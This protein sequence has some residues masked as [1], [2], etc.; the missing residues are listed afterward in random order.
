[1][2][3]STLVPLIGHT[4]ASAALQDCMLGLGMKKMPKGDSTTR[5]RTQDKL[6]SLEFD[7]TESY[8]GRNVREPV[9]D[10][11]FTLE[12][13]DVH[14]GYLGE[15]PFGLSL[16]M[17]RQQVD[18]ALGRALDEDPKAEVQ[19]Y[20]RDDFLIIVFYGGKGRKIDTFRFTRP[21]VHSARKF[22]IELQAA[23]AETP[24]AA[25]QPLSAPELLSFL[26]ASPDDAA[27]GAWLDQHG[28][29]DRPHAAPGVDGHGAA[30]D[31]TLREARLSEIDENERHGVALIY[32]SRESH[33][34]LFSAEAAGQG[35][36]L[37]QAAFYGPGVSGRAGFQGELP[38]GLRFA[39]GPAQVREKLSAPIAR[40]V[41][42]GLPAELW[43]DKDWHLNI[44]YTADAG[45]VAIVH[46]R[47]PNRYDLEM[48]GA[49][50]SEASRNAPDLEKLNAAI[51]LAV[52]DAK[53]QAALAPLAWNQDARDEAGRGDE[54]FRYLKSHG[55]SLYFRDG[56]DVGTTVLAGYCVNRAGDM[57]S[58]GYPGPLPF[59]LA[60]STRLEDIIPRVG[61]DPDA[62]GVA[63][64]T[65]YFLWNL[66]GFR[67]HVLYSLIDWQV[68]R[69]TCSGPVA[70]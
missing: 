27:F 31:E 13:F 46:V 20:R 35:F 59:G 44:S 61:R 6:V 9:G 58:A 51:G 42:H 2:T 65:G 54:V 55:L 16:A 12:S 23:A 48:I 66:P 67:L 32:E 39:D 43:V 40:R 8:M 30:S 50:S 11:G 19:T 57:D 17:D 15:L 5:V 14:Q 52:D 24:G 10:G 21:N 37:K 33:G 64:D 34:R 22:N 41:L 47:R 26:G 25:A 68:Y 18:A 28:I 56:A 49:A 36:V 3:I 38:F 53:L 4:S 70:G 7:P 60:F 62:H 69:V 63:E 1:M 29:H 45:R